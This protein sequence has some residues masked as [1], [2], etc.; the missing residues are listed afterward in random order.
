MSLANAPGRQGEIS[1]T[2]TLQGHQH[3]GI[4]SPAEPDSSG[5]S[6]A[7]G[8]RTDLDTL[9][10]DWDGPNDPK[11]PRNWSRK[12]KW[13]VTL[14][15]SSYAF[16]SPVSS[17]MIA[18]ASVQ[19]AGTFGISSSVII[20][21]ITSIFVLAY[22]IGPFFLGPLSEIYGRSRVL[23]L[24]NLWYFAWNLGCGFA[25]SGGQLIAFRFLAGF[26]GSAP[27]SIAGGLIG[28][29]WSPEERGQALAL[30]SLAP[31]LGPAVGPITGAWI[32]ER[33]TWRWVFW[34]TSFVDAAIQILGFIVLE[35]TYPPVLLERK[36]NRI[37]KSMDAEKAHYREVRTIFEGQDRSWKTIVS[38]TL[39]RPFMMFV[40]EPIIQLLGVYMAYLYGTMYLFLVTIPGMFEGVY[41]QPVGIAG[42]NYIALGVGLSGASQLNARSLDK[43]YV[44]LKNKNG[45]VGKP[46]FRLPSMFPATIL[47]PVGLFISGWTVQPNIPWI[48]PDIGIALVGAGIILSFQS[49]QTYIVDAFTLH[50]AS[51][52]AAVFSLRSLA[53][54]G[55][56]LFAPAMYSAL[57][58]GKG[59]T[60][61]AV[62]A[63]VIGC[64]APWIFWH[65]GERIRKSSRHAE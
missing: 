58:F 44:R 5:K 6:N 12:Q 47:L 16:T 41:K 37:R 54:F 7:A 35:E 49:I 60:I 15:V 14:I 61:L 64:P 28:D 33:S 48:A 25:Q 52:L 57:G 20:S 21:L 59:D 18:P 9:I 31:L 22:A 30:Y 55:F 40:H 43:V 3:T 27:L 26:G 38:K 62:V 32:A 46:E 2:T 13:V 65:Y 29:C 24:A 23:Q 36:A 51:A 56:P 19:V 34:A 17:S 4:E 11:N 53:G 42:L 63:I 10:V 8:P 39:V 1:R 45:G 50:A